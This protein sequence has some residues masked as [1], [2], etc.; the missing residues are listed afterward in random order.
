MLHRA[1]PPGDDQPGD[2]FRGDCSG[3]DCPGGDRPRDDRPGGDGRAWGRGDEPAPRRTVRVGGDG[4]SG[5]PLLRADPF[6]DVVRA[7]Q[8]GLY[9]LAIRLT[10][11]HA[12]ADDLVQETFVRAWQARERGGAEPDL[13]A[14]WLRRIAVRL[15]LNSRRGRLT[16][17]IVR[18]CDEALHALPDASA[19]PPDSAGDFEARLARGLARLSERERAVFVLRHLDDR[20]TRD[21]ADA[22]DVSEGTVKTLLSRAVAKIKPILVPDA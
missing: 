22:L 2:R 6:G 10:G 1:R 19:A 11:D 7:H 8:R 3:G 5:R 12:A 21:T 14:A 16:S 13:P 20:T 17:R 9:A 18:W 15:F 4:G